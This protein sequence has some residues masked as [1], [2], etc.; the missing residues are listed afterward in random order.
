MNRNCKVR[1]K[2]QEEIVN[3]LVQE[4]ILG[5]RRDECLPSQACSD[6][7]RY[8]KGHMILPWPATISTGRDWFRT[9][10]SNSSNKKI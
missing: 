8:I 6:P 7:G 1:V 10:R 5:C 2:R 3:R 4:Y 9:H